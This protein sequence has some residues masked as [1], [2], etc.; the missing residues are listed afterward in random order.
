MDLI[1]SII[2]FLND[3]V[4][5]VIGVLI[6]LGVFILVTVGPDPLIKLLKLNLLTGN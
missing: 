6:L 1:A 4:W 2:S 5:I 3:I